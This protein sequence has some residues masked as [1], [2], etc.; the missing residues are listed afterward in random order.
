M[1]L[2]RQM[3]CVQA[4]IAAK[5]ALQVL[6]TPQNQPTTTTS[7]KG[8]VGGNHSIFCLVVSSNTL[9]VTIILAVAFKPHKSEQRSEGESHAIGL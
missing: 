3:Q 7:T 1:P 8:D 4:E 2:F 6:A 9:A 5:I